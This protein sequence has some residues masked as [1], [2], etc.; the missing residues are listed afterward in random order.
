MMTHDAKEANVRKAL[1][2]IDALAVIK[3][4]SRFIRI[5]NEPG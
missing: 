3:E 1:A 4:Q 2:E 5:E